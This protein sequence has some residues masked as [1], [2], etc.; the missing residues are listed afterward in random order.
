M[1]ELSPCA[2]LLPALYTRSALRPGPPAG[3]PLVSES[4]TECASSEGNMSYWKTVCLGCALF[5]AT[6]IASSAHAQTYL[7]TAVHN[8]A[9][10]DGN[11]PNSLVV[12]RN[13]NLY[14]TT[15]SGGAYNLG[16]VFQIDKTGKEKV[17]YSFKGKP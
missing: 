14:G 17:L 5:L 3:L 9:G 10:P 4:A 6:A 13:G 2:A 11:S 1:Q 16:T 12:A 7:E 8:F 15:G